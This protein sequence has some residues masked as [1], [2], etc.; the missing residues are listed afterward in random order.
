ISSCDLVIAVTSADETNMIICM[1]AKK[2]GCKNTIARIRNPEYV[3]QSDLIKTSMHIDH[4]VNPELATADEIV[5]YLV[6]GYAL[7]TEDF[8]LGKVSLIDFNI[9]HFPDLI[10]KKI[11]DLKNMEEILIVAISRNGEI[12]IPHGGV[13]LQQ[14]DILYLIG[15]KENLDQLIKKEEAYLEKPYVKNVMILGGGKIGYYLANKLDALGIQVKIIEIDEERCKYLSEQL[16]NP[17]VILGD[18]TDINLLEEEDISSM[19]A[20][21]SVT[22]YDEENLLMALVAKQYGVNNI[23]AK[24]SRASYSQIIERLGI[25]IALNPV[26]IA[27]S[28][29]LKF[30][31]GGKVAAVSLLL[32][33]QAEVLEIIISENMNITEK[34]ISKLNLPKGII[35]GS[36]VRDETVIIPKGDTRIYPKDRIIVFCLQSKIHA[37]EK[38]LR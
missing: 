14:N 2:L 33:G 23:V 10:G 26:N 21:V 34:P 13:V 28:D 11:M 25:D 19:D 22:D 5:R 3:K 17:L 16:N 29:I 37:L 27:A 12:I 24:I 18:G 32:Q 38:F 36:I 35:L 6:K 4:I 8:A 7:H 31:R 15:K 30:I 1:I 20:F 9:N